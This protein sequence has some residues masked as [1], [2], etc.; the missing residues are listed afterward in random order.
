MKTSNGINKILG[1]DPGFGRMGWAV[2]SRKKNDYLAEEMGC[3]ETTSKTPHPER[4][5]RIGEGIEKIISKH[6]PEAMAIEKLFFTTNQK[7][8]LQVAEARG[9]AIYL[10]SI[11]KMPVLEYTPLE[12]KVAVCGYGK[13]DKKQIQNMI[14]ILL[15]LKA[16]PEHDDA[17]DALATA[18]TAFS[19]QKPY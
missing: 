16:A 6:R 7:T 18:L 4:I 2:V 8:A 13:A 15:K 11:A 19:Y 3:F 5:R 17:T 12:I 10:A 1:I 14:K 9:I